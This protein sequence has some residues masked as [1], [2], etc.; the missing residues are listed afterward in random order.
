MQ[1]YLIFRL[2]NLLYGIDATLVQE[3]FP[4]PELIPIA[5]TNTDVIGVF[6]LRGQV[7]PVIHLNLLWGYPLEGCNIEDY[8]I[9]FQWNS[10]QIGI[11]IHQVNEMLELDTEVVE[12][13]PAQELFDNIDTFFLSGV[14]RVDSD[15]ILLVDAEKIV[16]HPESLL[17]LIWDAETHLNFM[18]ASDSE[19]NND[20]YQRLEGIPLPSFYDLYCPDA[21]YQERGVFQQRY[22]Q[23]QE[24]SKN[25]ED[26]LQVKPLAV[27]SWGNEYFGFNLEVVR[28]FTSIYNLT[29]IPCCPKHIVGNMNLRGEIITLVDIRNVL[30]LPTTPVRVGSKVVVIEV[31]NIIAGFPVDKVLEV[32]NLNQDEMMPLTSSVSSKSMQYFLGMAPFEAGRLCV[33]DLQKILNKGGLVV[34][35][36]I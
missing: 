15:V 27:I 6:N 29:P 19:Q 13:E 35:E 18:A 20:E 32:I 28:E 14:I 23:L 1:T 9:V 16:R 3:I 24:I 10:L 36:E 31:E 2:H 11:V 26:Y 4:I 34:N 8:V 21:S 30:N 33:L 17:T 5:G 12:I 25:T 7:V 22:F